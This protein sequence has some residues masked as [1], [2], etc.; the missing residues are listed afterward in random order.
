M[1]LNG[2]GVITVFT[3]TI[4]C[5]LEGD[6]PPIADAQT[7]PHFM[8]GATDA[9]TRIRPPGRRTCTRL[10][11]CSEWHRAGIAERVAALAAAGATEAEA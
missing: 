9:G 3:D 1:L 4:G 6:D 7:H 8:T 10:W 11:A 5:T 2:R